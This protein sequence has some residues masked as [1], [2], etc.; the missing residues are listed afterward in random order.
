MAEPYRGFVGCKESIGS[1]GRAVCT[2]IAEVCDNDEYD[3]AL[4]ATSAYH[5]PQVPY[6]A[7]RVCVIDHAGW[8]RASQGHMDLTWTTILHPV[9]YKNHLNNSGSR[10]SNSK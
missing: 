6:I 2:D 9:K 8:C 3:E 1:A 4:L 5:V 7:P 10:K